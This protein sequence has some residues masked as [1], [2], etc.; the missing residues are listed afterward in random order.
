VAGKALQ[1]FTLIELL[2]ACEPKPWRR[3]VRRA[4][5]LI[6]LL[7][8][9]AIIAILAS[10]LLPAIGKARGSARTIACLNILKQ[11]GMVMPMYNSDED[12]WFPWTDNPVSGT[13]VSIDDGQ[14]YTKA[15]IYHAG[16]WQTMV[17]Y[18]PNEG[19]WYDD[20]EFK[21]TM[22]VWPQE[23]V[24]SINYTCPEN[25][26]RY[27]RGVYDDAANPWDFRPARGGGYQH[28]AR[29]AWDRHTQAVAEAAGKRKLE[30]LPQPESYFFLHELGFSYE[31]YDLPGLSKHHF[32]GWN[33]AFLDGHA[34]TQ[35]TR[36]FAPGVAPAHWTYGYMFV[37]R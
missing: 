32:S 22:P 25:V 14:T 15:N 30:R 23:D 36:H 9:I 10:M 12:G 11:Y 4:F 35:H 7:V 21:T 29:F 17:G 6:E 31:R 27:E 3:Q 33:L 8:V 34:N 26:S 20:W 37:L 2:V 5:T 16:F 1:R 13:Y 28:A 24:I 18:M 19:P